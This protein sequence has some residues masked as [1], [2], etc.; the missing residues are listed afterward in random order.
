MKSASACG[1]STSGGGGVGKTA[2]ALEIAHD[3]RK[4]P[5]K[6]PPDERFEA[7]V[8]VTAKTAELLPAGQV[9]R[10]PSFT[11]AESVDRA[12]GDL[13]DI[14]AIFRAARQAEKNIIISHFLTE[15]RILLILDNLENIDDQEL[16][17]FLRDLPAPSKALITTRHRIDVAVPV[18]LHMLNEDMAHELVFM[19]C[20]RHH[21]T[22][23]EEQ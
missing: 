5:A 4:E 23:T 1:L 22:L 16:M 8:W 7:I 11:D 6:L 9:Q 10:Q 12:I 20:E 17:I 21:L 3:W 13:L 19:E 14:P 2:L 15:H 18:Y